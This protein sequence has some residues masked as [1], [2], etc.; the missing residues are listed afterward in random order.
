MVAVR[1]LSERGPAALKQWRILRKA[2][3]SP[4]RLTTLVQTVLTLHHQVS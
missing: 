4:S 1:A 3:C 2:R